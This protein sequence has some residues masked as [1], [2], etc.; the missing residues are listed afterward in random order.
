MTGVQ[1]CALPISG[2]EKEEEYRLRYRANL[3]EI[4][5]KLKRAGEKG[6]AHQVL[7]QIWMEEWMFGPTVLGDGPERF[8]LW[9]LR[10]KVVHDLVDRAWKAGRGG[11][12]HTLLWE[13]ALGFWLIHAGHDTEAQSLLAD[14][15]RGWEAR[16]DPG[17]PWLV[18][19]GGTQACATVARFAGCDLDTPPPPVT[20]ADLEAAATKL[21][22]AERSL[23]ALEWGTP[24]HHLMLVHMAMLYRPQL[25]DRPQRL[26]EVQRTLA[27]V[28]K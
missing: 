13:S 25:L 23:S 3:R 28:T 20:P 16:L 2:L 24:L 5:S 11:D 7:P 12:L 10:T 22:G 1:T 8:E 17:D 26:A 4:Y 27:L 18:H 15:L 9:D 6:L 21:E 14:N 19:L